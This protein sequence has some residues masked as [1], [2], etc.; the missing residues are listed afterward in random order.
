MKKLILTTCV[1]VI[2][3][4]AFATVDTVTVANNSY[5]PSSLTID[6][7]DTVRFI[8]SAGVN[9]HPVVS[10]SSTWATFPM[11]LT[12]T[13]FDLVLT[14]PG[15]YPY[16]CQVHG[17]GMPGTIIVLDTT[18]VT[19]TSITTQPSDVS[20]TEGG[21]VAFSVSTVNETGFQWQENSGSGFANITDGGIYSGATTGTLTLTAVP[22]SSNVNRYICE[23]SGSPN[24]TSDSAILTVTA[25][26][27]G[28]PATILIQNFEYVP[29][30][31]NVNAG[32]SIQFKW[33]AGTHPTESI[34][35]TWSTFTLGATD[36]TFD[37]V[38]NTDGI[39]KY[40]CTAHGS[41]DG[42][43]NVSGMSGEIIVGTPD[44]MSDNFNK[45]FIVGPNPF[46]DQISIIHNFSNLKK[47]EVVNVIGSVLTSKNVNEMQNVSLK[48]LES[49]MYF[50]KAYD[51]NN[52]LLRTV[53]I[54]KK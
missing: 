44:G 5:S 10:D 54:I 42:E 41:N 43:G 48:N 11:G 1:T 20:I 23:V 26:P 40:F 6:L 47:I 33:V 16:R 12:D 21:D 32:D 37:L 15:T 53:K 22:L 2:G 8:S 38:I 34:D 52:D 45:T 35:A 50:V 24:I 13:L 30:T 25:T 17:S 31:L 27:T 28:G 39:Y 36:S 4:F 49:G 46:E 19:P 9:S 14:S 51:N 3:L 18:T 7:G 29:S